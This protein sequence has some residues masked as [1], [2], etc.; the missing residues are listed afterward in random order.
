MFSYELFGSSVQCYVATNRK[1]WYCK[2]VPLTQEKNIELNRF[3]SDINVLRAQIFAS[4]RIGAEEDRQVFEALDNA[5]RVHQDVAPVYLDMD[6]EPLPP[7]EQHNA[8]R[9]D[10]TILRN[11]GHIG[12]G[13]QTFI[14]DRL[15]SGALPI[16]D[17]D[18]EEFV[19]PAEP[20]DE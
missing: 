11:L 14:V 10:Y 12:A 4:L 5:A 20:I 13:S 19:P 9:D 18:P 2:L 3:A 16:Y 6:L 7:V 17:V 15:P 8:N 1:K